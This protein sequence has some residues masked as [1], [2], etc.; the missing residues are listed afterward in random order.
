MYKRAIIKSFILIMTMMS[1]LLCGCSDHK[2]VLTTG[3]EDKEV[4]RI[5]SESCYANE[6]MVYMVNTKN[7]YKELYGEQFLTASMNG[8]DVNDSINQ[9]VYS[10]IIRIKVMNLMASNYLISLDDSDHEIISKAANDY[11]QQLTAAEKNLFGFESVND[12]KAMYE[13][14]RIAEKLYDFLVKDINPEI[15]DDEARTIVVKEIYAKTKGLNENELRI[16]NSKF[17]DVYNKLLNGEDFDS[18]AATYSDYEQVNFSY[19]KMSIDQSIRDEAFDLSKDELSG[20]LTGDDGIYILYCVDPFN[21][22]ETDTTKQEIVSDRKLEA[23]ENAY[24]K[25]AKERR[26]YSNDEMINE[27]ENVDISQTSSSN[28]FDKYYEYF[29]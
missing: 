12:V 11:Y 16:L 27:L 19:T 4:F 3:F 18:V 24:N 28:F 26:F 17:N 5:D 7:Q 25:Y 15:S 9:A 6:V 29:K 20:I 13:E 1:F 8:V 22:D 23:F 2:I 10:K 14:Y 21:R